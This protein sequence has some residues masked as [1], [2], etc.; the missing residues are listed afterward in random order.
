[1]E[2]RRGKKSR[3]MGEDQVSLCILAYATRYGRAVVDY[4]SFVSWLISVTFVLY[5]TGMNDSVGRW[6]TFSI[7]SEVLCQCDTFSS[8][9]STFS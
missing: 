5:E 2:G 9:P 4:N 6:L 7:I 3:G 8:T 1:M